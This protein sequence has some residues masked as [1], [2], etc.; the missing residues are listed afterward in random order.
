MTVHHLLNGRSSQTAQ[1]PHRVG[2]A[3]AGRLLAVGCS[4]GELLA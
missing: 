4:S 3:Q 1:L 2:S